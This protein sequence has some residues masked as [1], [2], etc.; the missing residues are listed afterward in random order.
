MRSRVEV[1]GRVLVLGR[2]AAA[3]MPADHAQTQMYPRVADLY[4]LFADVRV[5]SLDFDLIEM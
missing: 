5:S 3:D 1:F 4:T 2:I